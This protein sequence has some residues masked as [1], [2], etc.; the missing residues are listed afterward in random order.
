MVVWMTSWF[1]NGNNLVRWIKCNGSLYFT[2]HFVISIGKKLITLFDW[3]HHIDLF[4]CDYRFIIDKQFLLQNIF[5]NSFFERYISNAV[6]FCIHVCIRILCR[7]IE[8]ALNIISGRF[9][10]KKHSKLP[11]IDHSFPSDIHI[12]N[13]AHF[14]TVNFCHNI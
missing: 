2:G 10:W 7:C 8:I 4:Y 9:R 1:Q 3:F 6:S 11:K 13:I 14:S 5:A 12:K